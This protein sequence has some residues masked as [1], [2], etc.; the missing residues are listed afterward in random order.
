MRLRLQESKKGE[1]RGDRERGKQTYSEKKGLQGL[2]YF[3]PERTLRARHSQHS[4]CRFP[5]FRRHRFVRLKGGLYSVSK[6]AI[7]ARA[8]FLLPRQS[9]ERSVRSFL[10]PVV[11]QRPER[12]KLWVIESL[13]DNQSHAFLRSLS[14]HTYFGSTLTQNSQRLSLHVS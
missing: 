2:C 4:F 1:W 7:E 10:L 9:I 11:G 12:R 3:E 13:Y 8:I 5:V 14:I 6:R